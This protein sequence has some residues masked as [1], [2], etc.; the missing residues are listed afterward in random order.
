MQEKRNYV[1]WFI[2]FLLGIVAV[3]ALIYYLIEKPTPGADVNL[4]ARRIETPLKLWLNGYLGVFFGFKFLGNLN[5]LLPVVALM[6][7]RWEKPVLTRAQKGMLVLMVLSFLLIALKGYFNP[8]YQYTLLPLVLILLF[9]ITWKLFDSRPK[10]VFLRV[11]A[12]SFLIALAGFHIFLQLGGSRSAQ[13]YEKLFGAQE[14]E[15]ESLKTGVQQVEK[16]TDFIR[17]FP[18]EGAVYLVN[19]LPDFYYHLDKKGLYYWCGDDHYYSPEGRTFLLRN[20][21]SEQVRDYL[22]SLNCRYVYTAPAYDVYSEAF[23]AFLARYGELIAEDSEN[24]TLYRI[25]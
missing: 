10:L 25:L 20:R 15:P 1:I 24:H 3:D 9:S 13:H 16:L 22:L 8:R 17:T 4:S 6:Y 23:Q 7:Y 21:N 11:Y 14:K 2:V 5:W 19:N 18:D 12:L